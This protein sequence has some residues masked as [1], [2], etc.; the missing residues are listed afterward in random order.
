MH[1]ASLV[2]CTAA[3]SILPYKSSVLGAEIFLL[4]VFA[5][6]EAVRLYHGSKGNKTERK[7][8]LLVA[9]CLG[10]A[11]AVCYVF[12]LQWQTYVLR[13]EFILNIIGLCFV[14]V[15]SL[16]AFFTLVSLFQYAQLK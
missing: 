3:G 10:A 11:T 15:E 13:V 12:Y 7:I 4:F 9:F 16:F 6:I 5:V 8:P 14:G 1:T 2:L